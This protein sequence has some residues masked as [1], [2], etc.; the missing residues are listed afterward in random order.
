MFAHSLGSRFRDETKPCVDNFALHGIGPPAWTEEIEEAYQKLVL[1]TS[2]ESC[3]EVNEEEQVAEKNVQLHGTTIMRNREFKSAGA[4]AEHG[5]ENDTRI[6]S[7][8]SRLEQVSNFSALIAL[9]QATSKSV[10]LSLMNAII[11]NYIP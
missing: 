2:N 3:A 1:E 7:P 11:T 8:P 4:N 5:R 9:F 6:K 10:Q